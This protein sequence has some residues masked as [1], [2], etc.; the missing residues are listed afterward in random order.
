MDCGHTITSASSIYEGYVLPY[1]TDS[2]KIGGR[3][4]NEYLARN[5]PK[6]ASMNQNT[7][8]EIGNKIKESG[9]NWVYVAHNGGEKRDTSSMGILSDF[10]LPDG[11]VKFLNIIDTC[12][13]C[14]FIN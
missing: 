4:I 8:R 13:L 7:A 6:L 1:A 3:D 10:Q 14:K 11:N 12:Y 5:V 2:I 9:D